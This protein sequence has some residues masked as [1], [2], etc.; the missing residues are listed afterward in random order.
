MFGCNFQCFHLKMGGYGA[1]NL[2][3]LELRK[4]AESPCFLMFLIL[5]RNALELHGFNKLLCVAYI[6]RRDPSN[7]NTVD[8]G[9]CSCF[10]LYSSDILA[11]KLKTFTVNLINKMSTASGAYYHWNYLYVCN[12]TPQMYC[13]YCDVVAIIDC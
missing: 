4:S 9:Y 6:E 10:C 13:F 7:Y 3:K 8:V 1:I 5:N 11:I 2:F 12:Q